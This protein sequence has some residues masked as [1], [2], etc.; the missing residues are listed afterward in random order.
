MRIEKFSELDAEVLLQYLD[1]EDSMRDAILQ[2]F[3]RAPIDDE[4]ST[5]DENASAEAA[6][7]E[8]LRGESTPLEQLRHAD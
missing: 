5:D 6:W 8:F 4:P 7:A 1:R 3:A 2:G